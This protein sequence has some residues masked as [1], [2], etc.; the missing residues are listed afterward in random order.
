MKLV[1]WNVNW[2][3]AWIKKWTFFDYIKKE[4][5]DIIWLQEVKSR[6]DQLDFKDIEEI[7]N[8]WYHIYWNAAKRPWYSWTALL[9]KQKPINV[10]NWINT[11]YLSLDKIETDE[12][13]EENY[14]WRVITAE[15]NDFYFITVYTP[16][17]KND[18]SRLEYRSIWDHVFLKYIKH[19]ELDKPVVFCWDLNVA[20][21]EI[22]LANPWPN[23]TTDKKP[24]SAWFTDTERV[25]MDEII[26]NNLIDTFRYFY[27]E[28]QREY[29]WWSNFWNARAR[30]TGW[31]IDYFIVSEILKDK[32]K[33]AFI[34]QETM[35]SDHCPV[36][37]EFK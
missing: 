36:W 20:H 27:P 25:W 30:N 26:K 19:L 34:R 24:W 23:K 8:L 9:T 21:K 35:W 10:Y 18:L 1:S 15:Y 14:E 31:R 16:N 12:V 6:L 32:L 7:E 3:R 4:S 22:D 17:A 28:K 11:S 37:I 2:I 29:T 13:I 5:P 33:D